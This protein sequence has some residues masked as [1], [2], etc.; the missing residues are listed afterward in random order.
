MALSGHH[1]ITSIPKQIPL[2]YDI[3]I[4]SPK[5]AS[6]SDFDEGA[7]FSAYDVGAFHALQLPKD[8][9]GLCTGYLSKYM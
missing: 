6:A 2:D 9:L 3:S 7:F 4:T 1:F 5:M 8:V